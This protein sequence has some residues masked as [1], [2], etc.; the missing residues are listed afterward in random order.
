MG[1]RRSLAT[2][3]KP[4]LI[5]SGFFVSEMVPERGIEPRTY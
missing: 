4:F 2:I 1:E 3:K 5:G